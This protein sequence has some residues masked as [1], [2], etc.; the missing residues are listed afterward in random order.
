MS[1]LA[2]FSD[3]Q[4][5]PKPRT[6]LPPR[7]LILDF[8][9]AVF[10][11]APGR[12]GCPMKN[13]W[14]V[15]PLVCMAVAVAVVLTFGSM[16]RQ[17]ARALRANMLAAAQ[18][19][20][21][22]T[23]AQR[24]AVLQEWQSEAHPMFRDLAMGE[25]TRRLLA[26][27]T[28]STGGPPTPS[29]NFF[30]NLTTIY[31][32]QGDI[33][34]MERT[35]TCSLTMSSASYALSL[36]SFNY[37]IDGPTTPNYDQILHNAAQ[38]KTNGGNFPAGC[39]DPVT[40]VPSRK[41]LYVGLTQA[42]NKVFAD[43]FF[44]GTAQEVEIVVSNAS[45]GVEISSEEITDLPNPLAMVAADLNGD[46]NPDLVVINDAVATGT[47]SVSV[48]LGDANGDGGF[49]SPTNYSLPGPVAEAAVIDDFNGDGKLDIVA[50]SASTSGAT[51]NYTLSFFAGEGNG[52][53]ATAQP[54]TLMPPTG[55]VGEPYAGLISASL[56]N[57]GKKDLVTATGIVLFGNG[58]GTFT[59]SATEAF[60]SEG[61]NSEFG[62]N[63]VAA[64]FNKDGKL[65]LALDD[66]GSIGIFL[67]NGDGTFEPAG[68]YATINNTSYLTGTDLDG[69]GNPD[70]YSGAGS[71]GTYG[72]DQFEL[73][74]GYALMGN[75]DGTFQGAPAM[76]FVYTGTN[77]ADLNG[78]H[79]PDGVGLNAQLNSTNV[80][81]TSYLGKSNG[82]FT[83]AQTF[84]ISPVTIN[85][86]SLSFES[87]D[88]FALGDVTGD[89]NADLVFVPA[90]FD[91]PTG[92]P[93]YFLATG[94]GDGTFNT[95]VWIQAPS[96]VAAGDTD[97]N[98]SVSDLFVADVNGDGKADLIYTYIDEDYE[99][100]I[101]YEGVAV[102]LSTGGGNF[103]APQVIQ[104][105]KSTTA[106]TAAA[107][108]VA[109]VGH[110]RAG[111][112]LDIFTEASTVNGNTV[113]WQMQLYLGNGDGTFGA[114][115][116]PKVAD[117]I[118][119]PSF[120]SAVGQIVLADMNGDGKPDLLTLGTTTNGNKAELAIALGNGDGTFQTPTILDFAGGSSLGYGLAAAD[121]NG[122]GKMDV[123]IAGFNPPEDTGIFLGNGD[124]T[125][126]SAQSSTGVVEPA[127]GIA[128]VLYGAATTADFN[129]DGKPD[130]VA[131]STVLINQGALS[132]LLPTTT[133]VVPSATSV[134]F[135]TNVTLT[136]TVSASSTPTGS[137]TFSDGNTAL[138]AV[139]LNG[140]GVGTYSTSALS[141]GVHSITASYAA[142]STFGG[143][144][145]PAV[146]VT[147]TQPVLP[148]TTSTLSALPTTVTSGANVTFTD[149]VAPASG[150]GT[151]TG[152]VTF[153]NGTT[154]LGSSVLAGGVAT[155]STTSLPVGADSVTA[156]YGGDTNFSGSTS[157]AVTVTVSAVAPSFTIA[158]SPVSATVTAGA[159]TTTTITV[160]PTGGFNSQVSFACTGL[161]TGGTCSL[162]PTT[163]TPNGIAAATTT[164][165]IGT[166]TAS[167]ALRMPWR[168]G[169]RSGGAATL[170]LLAAGAVWVFGRR[171]DVPWKRMLPLMLLLLLLT[172]AAVAVGC[173]GGSGNSGGGGG[174]G[175]YTITVTGT[176]GSESQTATFSLTVG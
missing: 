7:K 149:T 157:N 104:T 5:N 166:T 18:R 1:Q 77:L 100:R 126:Q 90:G 120:G 176:S 163:V 16:K 27:A 54:V 23:M 71:A 37:S 109:Q 21:K 83:A 63:V 78:D 135:G 68:A 103:A 143:S 107:P 75:G 154:N 17:S 101:Y 8:D 132:T 41:V 94:K 115:T 9:P 32:L 122:D 86:T 11:G 46:G 116:L 113:T 125:V 43:A 20:P 123:A 81:M 144:I 72:G 10:A 161:P 70:L 40:G 151:P 131:G 38:L 76:P 84:T 165:T 2:G 153:M 65:D 51:T 159:S 48:L 36:P 57:N 92:L 141:V 99:T 138:A 102:Q 22:F 62:P 15:A 98:E 19:Y 4:E 105:Y 13:R 111:G 25:V 170:A 64:D 49:G 82:S 29:A 112:A 45:T 33:L 31:G 28:E 114:A 121:F 124:G 108:F 97:Y 39:G 42:G 73:N 129:G 145:S 156:V 6:I 91:G 158:A 172:I 85:G 119:P 61:A 93:G 50:S 80:T 175:G 56:R 155:F 44:N 96:F 34:K 79:I 52:S 130:L 59:Q 150:T 169:S 26:A 60:P 133:T 58:D 87:L 88:S 24:R 66:G 140:S 173:G 3:A 95:P 146:A 12:T 110:T 171:K 142:N 69:D 118:G 74:Q 55:I 89:G 148:A 106:P 30:G 127:E 67:G 162:S 136:A 160:T 134:A 139:T 168:P 117:N 174:G 164:L 128:F 167:G 53:F 35:A 14:L 47:G 137:V 147:V 152:M